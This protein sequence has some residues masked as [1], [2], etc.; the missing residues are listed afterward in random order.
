MAC[1]VFSD[2]LY[3]LL[4][5]II[6]RTS[7]GKIYL[8]LYGDQAKWVGRATTKTG[9]GRLVRYL[10]YFL[11]MFFYPVQK[12]NKKSFLL[13]FYYCC[14]DFTSSMFMIFGRIQRTILFIFFSVGKDFYYVKSSKAFYRVLLIVCCLLLFFLDLYGGF[15]V[16]I[17]YKTVFS[18]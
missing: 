7:Y 5:S 16:S 15:N 1:F 12:N 9:L 13:F 18:H 11:F 17:N 10:T 4:V 6:G 14:V 8:V 2:I 3:E